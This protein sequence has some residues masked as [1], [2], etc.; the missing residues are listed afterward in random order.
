M[1]ETQH[2]EWKQSWR[3]DA[4]RGICGVANAEGGVMVIGRNDHGK[5]VGLKDARKLLEDLPNKDATCW[6]S[7]WM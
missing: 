7:W 6:A 3:D 1:S 5:V 4:L 2:I